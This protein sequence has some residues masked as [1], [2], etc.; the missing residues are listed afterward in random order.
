MGNCWKKKPKN[1]MFLPMNLTN[2]TNGRKGKKRHPAFAG[3]WAG[4]AITGGV[5][6][7]A[8]VFDPGAPLPQFL[9]E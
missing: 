7:I 6:K 9:T 4:D 5:E 8:G 2:D 1:E 3:R